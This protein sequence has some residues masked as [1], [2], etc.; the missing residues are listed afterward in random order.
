VP[1][2]ESS[3]LPPTAVD[4]Q[5]R[6]HYTMQLASYEQATKNVSEE[7]VAKAAGSNETF[8]RDMGKEKIH[9]SKPHV[10]LGTTP[11][12][13]QPTLTRRS[14]KILARKGCGLVA[15]TRS[16]GTEERERGFTIAP[17]HV[18][19][20]RGRS[21]RERRLTCH[22]TTRKNMINAA[23]QRGDGAIGG[24]GPKADVQLGRASHI[25]LARRWVSL[26]GGFMNK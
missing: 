5:G 14:T 3:A 6:D 16:K 26:N 1:L 9:R 10:N 17:A 21:L 15:S 25:S 4:V 8:G 24:L 7:V 11:V 19:S 12:D 20:S 23:A 13:P 18:E 2:S 22:A